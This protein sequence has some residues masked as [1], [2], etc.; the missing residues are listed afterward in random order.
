MLAEKWCNGKVIKVRLGVIPRRDA[1]NN[2]RHSGVRPWTR[3]DTCVG[4][5][6]TSRVLCRVTR[7]VRWQVDLFCPIRVPGFSNFSIKH[8][9]SN[10]IK[11]EKYSFHEH[12]NNNSCPVAPGQPTMMHDA[13]C[14]MPDIYPSNRYAWRMLLILDILEQIGLR[15]TLKWIFTFFFLLYQIYVTSLYS[16]AW[17]VFKWHI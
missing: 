13:W 2:S 9:H 12:G 10:T 15:Y 11:I 4:V 7:D 17:Y 16:I 1:E 3:C 6:A 8:R 14:V 5:I